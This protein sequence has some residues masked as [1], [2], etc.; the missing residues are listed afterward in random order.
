VQIRSS[1]VDWPLVG[2]SEELVRLRRLRSSSGGVSAL[3]TGA[4][5]VGKSRLARAA[6][7]EAAGEG[8]ATL[9]VRG[10]PGLG[11]MPLW[12]F[13]TVLRIPNSVRLTELTG[14]IET[15]LNAI[16]SPKGLLV[17][18][19]D[20]Q[21]LDEASSGL[22]RQMVAA[23]LIVA[24]LTTRSVPT[25][26]DLV[27]LWTEGL[28]ERI[29]LQNLSQR[30]TTELLT[31]AL[32]GSV[33]ESSAERIWHVTAGNPLYLHEVVLSSADTGA[34][35]EVDGEWRWRGE[36]ARGARLQEIVAAR[37]GRLDPDELTAMEMLALA[38][39]LPLELVTAH[40]SARAVANLDARALVTAERS[41]QRVEIAI[42][43]PVHAEVLRSTM[44]A[45]QQ[46]SIRSNL[47]DALTATG[48]RRAADRVR[49]A[50][51]SLELGVDVDVI[52]LARA[53]D[54]SLL[55]IGPAVSAR[56]T[57]ILPEAGTVS[58]ARPAV[59]EDLGMAARLAE[60]AFDRTGAVVEG[61]ALART[62]VW[63]GDIGRAEA[64]LAELTG[65]AETADDRIRLARA[66]A[67]VG[68]W[69]RHQVDATVGLIKAVEAGA[70]DANPALIARVY[71]ELAWITW[72]TARPGTALEYAQ[73]AAHAQGVDLSHSV[74][75]ATAAAALGDLGRCGEAIALVDQALPATIDR[76][77]PL[78]LATMLF[79]RAIALLRMGELEQARELGAWVRDVALSDGLLGPT[80]HFGMLLGA[81]LLRQGR[82]ASAGR[83]FRDA[84]GLLAERDV[85]G[86][87]PG[88]LA[89]LA[90][91][92]ALA[93]EEE[94]AAAA[95][96][97]ARRTRS[98]SRYFDMSFYL[99]EIELHCLT[100][101]R[102]AALHTA[103][104]AVGWARAAGI[105]DDEA[106]ALDAWL[107]LA[108]S[109]TLAERLT[110]LKVVTDSKLVGVLADHARA[111]VAAD[112]QS[113]LDTA[114]R[115]ASLTAW[116]LAAD[117]AA[118]AAG[119]FERRH[120]SRAAQA[121]AQA[122][123]RFGT[124][125]EGIIPPTPDR[126]SGPT[127]LT[128]REREIATLAA[129][130]RPSKQIA[131]QM[132]LSRRT[133]ENHLYRVYLKL[134]VTDRAGL[135]AALWPAKST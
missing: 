72:H 135:A 103:G 45:L 4:A 123:A 20:S 119:L 86:Y 27:A 38:R 25:P 70:Q 96:V 53:A 47:V 29:E 91:A 49:L 74:A 5:G 75:A 115:F 88:A 112:A 15:E 87:R 90:R 51:W 54:A 35:R 57:E 60:A 106:Q 9:A 83:M 128:R 24:I 55:G 67:F 40:S 28:A 71:D 105:V 116:Q 19:D 73:R 95:L 37:L 111:L 44:P 63:T 17:L 129:A 14:S 102:N 64:V 61:A 124:H 43:H 6:L 101:R 59:G 1:G 122:A 30:E 80:A 127:E 78:R 76:G 34:L 21:E 97:E 94:S 33:E 10:S 109:P 131:E 121:A 8:W 118:A 84:A 36:W 126:P 110:E 22:L 134:G 77:N 104:E 65:K 48:A 50:C 26:A 79:S 56:L 68:F 125:C 81:I 92:R 3:I 114:D 99:A 98:V 41:G 132:D 133:V 120:Q 12:P 130:G 107:R 58:A 39:T 7:A 62:L 66:A 85:W 32:G 2:R 23:R 89:G 31:A 108:P 82:P 69:G 93:G 113:L 42:A 100:G 117:A 16:R 46:R 18:A 11:A 13:R 52:T